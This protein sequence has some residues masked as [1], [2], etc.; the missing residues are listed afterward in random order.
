MLAV[1]ADRKR[2]A[3]VRASAVNMLPQYRSDKADLV[4][5]R[6]LNDREPV[7]RAAACAYFAAGDVSER[8]QLLTPL[9][10]D[11]IRLVRSEAAHALASIP[12][13][14]L[15]GA[16]RLGLQDALQERR[17]ALRV[18][19]DLAASHVALALLAEQQRQYLQAIKHYGD[20]I[21]VQPGVV[22]PRS[23]LA[24]LLERLNRSDEAKALREQELPLLLRD[25][26][27]APDNAALQ[28]RVG[29]ACYLAGR[30]EEAESAL[31]RAV[32]LSPR[33]PD[34]VLFL[35]LFYEKQ[36]GWPEAVRFAEQL[37]AIQPEN[38]MFV[39]TLARFQAQARENEQ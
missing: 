36:Q 14:S 20:A 6:S 4:A 39:Q 27:L 8:L 17:D 15:I 38:A 22:G 28:Y 5:K 26:G 30:L 35:A 18:D 13:Q 34:F 29:L 25:A 16:A 24:G 12:K 37:V 23:N 21:R 9:L 2:P 1:A 31:N 33:N 3:I 19:S 32:E 11:P 10:N 7:V